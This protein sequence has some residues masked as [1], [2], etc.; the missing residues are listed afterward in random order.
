MT[1]EEQVVAW[2]ELTV[3]IEWLRIRCLMAAD[4]I[5]KSI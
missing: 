3:R 2:A 1:P 4:R 5:R